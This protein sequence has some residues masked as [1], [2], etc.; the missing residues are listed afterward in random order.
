[1]D[2]VLVV[3]TLPL[4]EVEYDIFVPINKKVGTIKKLI[5]DTIFELSDGVL[6]HSDNFK[7][8]NK[9]TGKILEN[10]SFVKD[11]NINNGT[12]LILL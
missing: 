1:M 2:K 10:D 7:L 9:E 11:E 12:R 3:V 5:I 6:N 8:Y 4:L